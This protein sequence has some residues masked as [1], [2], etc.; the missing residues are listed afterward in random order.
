MPATWLPHRPCLSCLAPIAGLQPGQPAICSACWPNLT[1]A[2]KS[3]LVNDERAQ[4]AL[5]AILAMLQGNRETEEITRAA[6]KIEASVKKQQEDMAVV[7]REMVGFL[8]WL[9]ERIERGGDGD[10]PWL[11]SLGGDND[12]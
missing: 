2:E 8:G 9:K 7:R 3:R 11:D 5:H 4:V 12:T 6:N 1:L 10:E